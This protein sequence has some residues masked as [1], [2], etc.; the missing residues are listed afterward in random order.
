MQKDQ[1]LSPPLSKAFGNSWELLSS[2]F[3]SFS[4]LSIHLT[5]TKVSQANKIGH[6]IKVRD[7]SQFHQTHLGHEPTTKCISPLCLYSSLR[8]MVCWITLIETFVVIGSPGKLSISSNFNPC[9]CIHLVIAKKSIFGTYVLGKLCWK[10]GVENGGCWRKI[11]WLD[12]GGWIRDEWLNENLFRNK[13]KTL[14]AIME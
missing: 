14:L 13:N 2:M 5:Q 10:Q 11:V 3:V 4:L 8:Y 9:V 1:S 6:M 12:S 7:T